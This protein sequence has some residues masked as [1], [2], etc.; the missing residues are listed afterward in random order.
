MLNIQA[1]DFI[2]Y[3]VSNLE[4][5][6]AF[7]ENILGLKRSSYYVDDTLEWAEFSIPPTTLSLYG[8]QVS[9]GRPP[10]KSGTLFL[11]VPDTHE[12]FAYLKDKNITFTLEPYE[13]E[14]CY[15][16]VFQ[17]PDGNDI[18]LHSRKDGTCG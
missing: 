17:D 14:V 8:T 3:E 7:Y 2:A 12:A 10:N 13:T 6:V 1:V 5:A 18:G 4:K 11:A 16:A 15:M 9:E